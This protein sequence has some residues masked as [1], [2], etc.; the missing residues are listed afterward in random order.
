MAAKLTGR[1]GSYEPRTPEEKAKARRQQK[2]RAGLV[3]AARSFKERHRWCRNACGKEAA[4]YEGGQTLRFSGCC[5][6][7]CLA[8]FESM[9]VPPNEQNSAGAGRHSAGMMGWA[10]TRDSCRG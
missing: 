5:S 1:Y 3:E 10:A 8:D 7:E 4:W 6:A 9:D 2:A